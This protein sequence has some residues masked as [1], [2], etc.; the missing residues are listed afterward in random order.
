M[1]KYVFILTLLACGT[2][3][4]QTPAD[5]T[6]TEEN[7]IGGRVERRNTQR[8]SNVLGTPVYYNL[9]GSVREGRRYNNPRPQGDYIRPDHHYRNTLKEHYNT[10]FCE[11]EGLFGPKDVAIGMNFTYL[12]E[13]WGIYGSMLAGMRY[14]FASLGAAYRFSDKQDFMDWHFYGGL[15]YGDGLGGEFGMRL[16]GTRSKSGFGWC[17]GSM[18]VAVM[19]GRGYFTLGLSLDITALTALSLMLFT[20]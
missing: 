13:R 11:F 17:S 15:I 5:T 20:W 14:N 12:P 6:D 4:S 7:V 16:A 10:Y 2:V 18:G 9:D 19:D 1:K 3:W 8:E